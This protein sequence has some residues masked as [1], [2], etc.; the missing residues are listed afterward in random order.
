VAQLEGGEEHE[1]AG[2]GDVLHR[3][4]QQ[5][6]DRRVIG[7]MALLGG[8]EEHEQLLRGDDLHGH[9]H[10]QQQGEER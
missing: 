8:G 7:V 9:G 6:D 2:P 3:H 5:D 1:Q 4:R 10:R